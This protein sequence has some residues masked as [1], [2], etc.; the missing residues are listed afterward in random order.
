[1]L[2]TL[3][4]KNKCDKRREGA[5]HSKKR[6]DEERGELNGTNFSF[7]TDRDIRWCVR[8][9]QQERKSI[10]TQTQG[11]T[12]DSIPSTGGPRA[13]TAQTNEWV[14]VKLL[15]HTSGAVPVWPGWCG[16]R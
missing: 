16:S 14:E 4:R 13:H 2:L 9:Q 1:M 8:A 3:I 12:P 5:Q 7:Y 10:H 6:S 11:K 15:W